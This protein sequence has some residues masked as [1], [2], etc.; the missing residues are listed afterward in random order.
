LPLHVMRTSSSLNTLM[1]SIVKTDTVPLL[2]VLIFAFGWEST[3]QSKILKFNV[4]SALLVIAPFTP[5]A[6][7]MT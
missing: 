6:A 2:A 5:L 7:T 1:P 4:S 3:Y